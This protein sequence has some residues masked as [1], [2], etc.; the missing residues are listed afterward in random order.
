METRSSTLRQ[1]TNNEPLVGITAPQSQGTGE[2]EVQF[3]K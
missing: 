3:Y 2:E 1:A